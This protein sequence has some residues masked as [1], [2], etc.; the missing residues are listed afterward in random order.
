M[1]F[2]PSERYLVRRDGTDYGP[3]DGATLARYVAEGSIEGEDLVRAESATKWTTVGELLED[4]P[5]A[6]PGPAPAPVPSPVPTPARPASPP[7]APQPIVLG[8]PAVSYVGGVLVTV[9]CCQLTGAIALVYAGLA[10]TAAARGDAAEYARQKT[11]A[12]VWLWV[13]VGIGLF[14]FCLY[15]VAQFWIASLAGGLS[16]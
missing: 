1:S 14:F 4:R 5:N 6:G 12:T 11:Q 2:S 10:N 16:P 15:G 7:T 13:S 3:Y 8:L 9:F